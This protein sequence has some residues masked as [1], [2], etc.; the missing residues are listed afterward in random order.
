MDSM[1]RGLTPMLGSPANGT[2][3]FAMDNSPDPEAEEGGERHS[4]G[5]FGPFGGQCILN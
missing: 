3:K 4:G 1:A 5:V 2:E